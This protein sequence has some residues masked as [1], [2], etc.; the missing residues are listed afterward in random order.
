MF[1]DWHTPLPLALIF[2]KKFVNI[3]GSEIA[4]LETAMLIIHSCHMLQKLCVTS[5]EAKFE[6][7]KI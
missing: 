6:F 5:L 2:C 7:F 1:T 4:F 3:T